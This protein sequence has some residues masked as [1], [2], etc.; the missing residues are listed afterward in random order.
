MEQVQHRAQFGRLP[1][2]LLEII[3]LYVKER[4]TLMS[5]PCA[6]KLFRQLCVPVLF[7][8]LRTGFSIAGLTRL[9]EVSRSDM[10]FHVR[11]IIYEA[12]SLVDPRKS[13]LPRCL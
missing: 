12:A 4:E 6:N 5:L 11:E 3:I 8:T 9:L 2:E 13:R 7:R 1:V 10:A